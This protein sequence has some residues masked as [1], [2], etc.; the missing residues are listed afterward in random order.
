MGLQF[1]AVAGAPHPTAQ[2]AGPGYH[3]RTLGYAIAGAA[4]IGAIVSGHHS[5]DGW[6]DPGAALA[7]PKGCARGGTAS[8]AFRCGARN[9][10][11]IE[12]F[13]DRVRTSF[14]V[15]SSHDGG[16]ARGLA[17]GSLR[18]DVL[19][20]H[21]V[22]SPSMPAASACRPIYT[23]TARTGPS[24]TC[25]QRHWRTPP[26]PKHWHRRSRRAHC[27]PTTC[28]ARTG[29]ARTRPRSRCMHRG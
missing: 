20:S 25:R 13:A 16:A 7:V 18:T 27:S 23:T 6:P 19:S 24:R 15:R 3:V 29:R 14:G 11:R 17:G 8:P 2:D 9:R 21:G 12:A 22:H 28:S 5:N 4:R 26:D 10:T 1:D